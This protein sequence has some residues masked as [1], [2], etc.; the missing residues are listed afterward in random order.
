MIFSSIA[1]F[2]HYDFLMIALI[3][4]ILLSLIMGALSPIV[5]SKKYSFIGSAISHSTLLG[6]AMASMLGL[7]ESSLL[8]FFVT[9]LITLIFALILARSSFHQKLPTD[10]L[11]GIFFTATMSAGII[12]QGLTANSATNL[13]N[14]LFGNVL[15][16]DSTDI[17][18]LIVLALL[19]LGHLFGN[20]KKWISFCWNEELAQLNQVPRAFFHYLLFTLLTLSIVIG[21][22]VA[23]IILVSSYLIIPG[24]FALRIAKN[25]HQ[26]FKYSILFAITSSTLA[27]LVSNGLNTTVGPTIAVTQA[28]LFAFTYIPKFR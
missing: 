7:A 18:L 26:V 3:A 27:L 1:D 4:T 10:S 15:L 25:I 8:F 16:V 21:L 5:V 6:L 20:F 24:A 19:V 13:F 9:T 11:I 23:G 22:K 14:Y 28:L 12:L 17:V 2:F